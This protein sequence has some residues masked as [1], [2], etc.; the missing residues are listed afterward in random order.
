MSKRIKIEEQKKK[1]NHHNANPIQVRLFA[2][3]LE[4]DKVRTACQHSLTIPGLIGPLTLEVG[5]HSYV[6][7]LQ[8]DPIL[9]VS[10]SERRL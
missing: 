4:F 8:A 7:N 5:N 2:T 1:K 3:R 6:F 10:S 9:F